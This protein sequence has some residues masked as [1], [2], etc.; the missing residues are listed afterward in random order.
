MCN[1]DFGVE[2]VGVRI[3]RG[4]TEETEV[5]RRVREIFFIAEMRRRGGAENR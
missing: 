2:G 1:W 3:H 5:T 4:G